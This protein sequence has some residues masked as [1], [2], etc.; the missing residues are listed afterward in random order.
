M[1]SGRESIP[2]AD[3]L[4]VL[5]TTT[6]PCQHHRNIAV[7]TGYY[8]GICL[9]IYTQTEPGCVPIWQWSCLSLAVQFVHNRNHKKWTQSTISRK[10]VDLRY[11]LNGLKQKS[12]LS[13]HTQTALFNCESQYV[14]D[15][16]PPI[17]ARIH[18][19][20]VRLPTPSKATKPLDP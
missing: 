7:R 6:M 20:G 14:T 17:R 3:R 15:G 16:Q 19:A 9:K 18:H 13:D 11:R 10:N 1:D 5:I 12:R 4:S 2:L 8:P